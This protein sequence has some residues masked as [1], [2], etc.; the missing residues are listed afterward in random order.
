MIVS[1][2][3]GG[4]FQVAAQPA[5][6]PPE[7]TPPDWSPAVGEWG[8]ISGSSL[9]DSGVGWA[10]TAPGGTSNYITVVT[11]WCGGV[12]NTSG[13]YRGG[14]FVTGSFLVIWGGGHGDYAGNEV[15]A[16]GP[17]ENDAPTWSR[18][19][20]PTIPAPDDV[21]RS[22]GYPVSRHT[23]D[24]LGY[25]PSTNQMISGVAAGTY[26]SATNYNV[27]DLF[28]FDT[29]PTGNPWSTADT[30]SPAFNGGGVGGLDAVS[31]YD[32][33]NGAYWIVGRGNSQKIGK[34]VPG[35]GWSSWDIDNPDLAQN[36][37]GAVSGGLGI[38]AMSTSSGGVRAV[39]IRTTP[40]IYTPSTTGSGPSGKLAMEW[41]DAGSRFVCWTGTGKTL[42]FLTPS[43]TPYSGG[44]AWTWSSS[45]PAGGATPTTETANGT[46]G[47]FRILT[48]SG[49]G[50]WVLVMPTQ[51]SG[52]YAY[53]MA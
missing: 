53:R 49:A 5:T 47:R 50:R 15:Y 35:S 14:S 45:T 51:S 17:L 36:S 12:L 23:Y 8:L 1:N 48:I 41:D 22:G 38:M 43:G 25:L 46:F 34:Y 29:N 19:I 7:V 32:A 40:A 24:C 16:Y 6:P 20:D 18:I 13:I 11:A 42:Y 27:T 3:G 10:G 9:T 4:G 44:A 2:A 37:K 31:G 33:T 28:D 39:D 52:V 26:H 30:G 21:S